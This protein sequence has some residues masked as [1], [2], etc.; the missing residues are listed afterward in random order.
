MKVAGCGEVRAG[1]TRGEV[2]AGGEAG[3][4]G[5]K[6]DEM[7]QKGQSASELVE[8]GRPGSKEEGDRRGGGEGE[9]EEEGGLAGAMM[10][11]V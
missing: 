1:L 7:W 3:S 4:Y 10:F 2:G 11:F 8:G 9:E 5:G 6:T